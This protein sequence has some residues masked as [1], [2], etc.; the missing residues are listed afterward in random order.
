[1]DTHFVSS[2]DG[3][4]VAYDVS[5]AGPALVLLHGGGGSRQEW[6]EAGYVSR[7]RDQYTVITLD[8]RG[9]GAS[10]QPTDP[11]DYAIDRMQQDI[12]A[13]ADACGAE[14]FAVWAMSHGGRVGRYLAA[15]PER[16][17]S[18]I[19]MSTLLGPGASAEIRHEVLDFCTQWP[20]ILQAQ[21]AGTL[22]LAT[23]TQYEQDFLQTFNV[24]AMLGW[25]RAMLDWP[26]FEP[27]DF[28]CPTLWLVGSED[29]RAV[30]NYRENQSSLEGTRVQ[31]RLL[32]GLGHEQVFEAIDHVLPILLEFTQAQ[33]KRIR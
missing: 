17:T 9:H 20:P 24:P 10:S 30:A 4:Q 14:R 19:L 21:Q 8:M 11:A 32:E 5:G 23:L 1:M 2:T 28:G 25:G 16:V 12:L 15:R 22:D 27:K 33:E 26:S 31:G 3:R 7:L 29:R 18:M 13:V 6:H